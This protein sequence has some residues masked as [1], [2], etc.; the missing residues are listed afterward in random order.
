MN[1]TF[2]IPLTNT[3][4]AFEI[5][6]AGITYTLT[7]KW[8][9]IGQSWFL[10]IGDSNNVPIATSIPLVTGDDLLDGLEYLEIGGQLFV[11]TNALQYP[12]AV[13]TLDN[14]GD[15]IN[16]YFVTSVAS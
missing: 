15:S 11:Y 14:L 2:L 3:P 6:L 9:D 1:Q 4:Q 16:L 7:V 12:D 13:P 8:N 5:D 10:D